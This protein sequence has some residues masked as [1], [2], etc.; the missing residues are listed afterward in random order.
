[1]L[2]LVAG[3]NTARNDGFF[4]LPK[5]SYTVFISFYKEL[6]IYAGNVG[7]GTNTP[8]KCGVTLKNAEAREPSRPWLHAHPEC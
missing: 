4:R 8:Y 5:F 1:M 3:I 7:I 2:W 6:R